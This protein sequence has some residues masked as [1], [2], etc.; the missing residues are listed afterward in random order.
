MVNWY[1]KIPSSLKTKY[2][3]PFY[4]IN[5][6]FDIPARILIVGNSG[7]GKSTLV[8]EILRRMADTFGHIHLICMN[9]EEPLY[10]YLSS[11][12]KPEELTIYE[13]IENIPV[14]DDLDKDLQHCVIFDDLVLEKK[15]DK[16]EEYFIRSRKIAKGV[17]CIYL[18]QTYFGVPKVIRLNSNYIICKKLSSTRDLKM[19]MKDFS[20]GL[21]SQE[22]IDIYKYCTSNPQDFLLVDIQTTPNE[23]FKKNFFDVLS[24]QNESSS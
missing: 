2:H 17:T 10:R 23:R 7:S 8:L 14:L 22:L 16:I 11:K 15:Q 24:I 5:H 19:M 9:K 18:T 13:G 3:N 1:Q 21:E 6:P 4:Q 12:L 20:L